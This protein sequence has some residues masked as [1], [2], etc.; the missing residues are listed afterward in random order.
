MPLPTFANLP[1]QDGRTPLIWASRLGHADVV[2]LLLDRGANIQATS[3]VCRDTQSDTCAPFPFLVNSLAPVFSQKGR[4]PLRDAT[5]DGHDD[6]A[7][8]LRA[9]GAH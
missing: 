1:S 4:T 5:A 7:A 3:K 6:V 9:R 8:I 2:T